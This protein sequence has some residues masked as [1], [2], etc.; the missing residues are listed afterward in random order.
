MAS[1]IK[2]GGVVQWLQPILVG[3]VLLAL[4]GAMG[5]LLED[6]ENQSIKRLAKAE[7]TRLASLIERDVEQRIPELARLGRRWEA[8][9]GIP[10]GEWSEEARHIVTH[11]EGYQA[12]S[13]VDRSFHVRWVVPLA[14]NEKAQ[15]LNLAF[16]E[17]RRT[18]LE[19]ARDY[20]AAT[21]TSPI[22]LVQGGKGILIYIPL[23]V[24]GEF[25]GFIS[26]VLRTQQWISRIYKSA[27]ASE[28]NSDFS[29][30]VIID[31]DIVF[32]DNAENGSFDSKKL[33]ATS[34]TSVHG[35]A[36][37]VSVYPT[38]QFIDQAT[39]IIPKVLIFAGVVFSLVIGLTTFLFQRASLATAKVEF[40]N[41]SLKSEVAERQKAEQSLREGEN[42]FK[43]FATSAADWF[44]ETDTE[45]RLNYVAGPFEDRIGLSTEQV[46]G[47]T[48]A[49][50]YKEQNNE[51]PGLKLV[52][53]AVGARQPYSNVELIW[54]RPDNGE[55]RH[56]SISGHPHFDETGEFL[57]YRGAGRDITSRK[58]LEEQL[59]RQL[60]EADFNRGLMEERAAEAA[61]MAEELSI[62]NHEIE[63]NEERVRAI[64]HTVVDAIITIDKVGTILTVNPASE[65]L[66][67]FSA[68]EM[69]SN[70]VKMLMPEDVA[71]KHDGYLSSYVNTR[72]AQVIGI[73][74]EVYGQHKDGRTFPMELAVSE[75]NIGGEIMFT[76]ILRDISERKEAEEKI[77]H[78][79]THDALTDLPSLRLAKDRIQA[80]IATA[81]RDE[82]TAAALF[83]DLDG[84]KS[85]NDTMGHEAGDALLIGVAKRLLDCVR[86]VDTVARIGGD[87]FLIVLSGIHGKNDAEMVAGK[88]VD[89][90]STPFSLT[91]GEAK[92]GASV[93]IALYPDHAKTAEDLIKQADQA[94]Y[95]IKYSGKNGYGLAVNQ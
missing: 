77:R 4:V 52:S 29:K 26:A 66:F 33:W 57:G 19:K 71:V 12:L 34:R 85:V 41:E 5:W 91:Q 1:E 60:E 73:G 48:R 20:K 40:I 30:R 24:K 3:V 68:A 49:E 10:R 39:S 80:A 14:G 13:W 72:E 59:Q 37:S 70:N 42:R 95:D 35:H 86:E 2:S 64:L 55:I 65:R 63:S 92:I 81:K 44:W 8:R 78:M 56:L 9:G 22:N 43:E 58:A 90:I 16:E 38:Q 47:K 28:T 25:D 50:V 15:G 18:A 17:R 76:G 93:G 51:Q 67:G 7:A 27:V 94:M 89:A 46:M 61:G 88:V 21:L 62:K 45:G 6:R 32:E 36:V 69:I 83:I 79:A 54:R 75:M 82:E 87:E 23:F 53:E 11:Y 31:G 84:F 74:R